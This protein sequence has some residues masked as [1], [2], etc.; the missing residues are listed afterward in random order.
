ME[1]SRSSSTLNFSSEL[2]SGYSYVHA[3]QKVST[4]DTTLY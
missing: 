4:T 1:I 2:L 3:M